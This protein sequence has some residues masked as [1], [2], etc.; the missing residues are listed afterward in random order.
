MKR[1]LGIL[2]TVLVLVS[3]VV[4]QG[5]RFNIDD[6][7]KC[8]ASAIRKFRLTVVKWRSSLVTC[9]SMTTEPSIRFT[10]CQSAV[11]S[12]SN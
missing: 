9:S 5:Q 8:G 10:S 6:L 7:M 1:S 4:A 11:A 3:A 12:Q 2:V